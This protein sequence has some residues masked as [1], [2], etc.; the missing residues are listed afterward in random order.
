MSRIAAERWET[1]QHKRLATFVRAECNA[2][3]DGMAPQ[4]FQGRLFFVRF[5]GQVTVQIGALL[6]SHQPSLA[7]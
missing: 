4:I 6:V 1:L 3:G 2:I 5:E 7:F